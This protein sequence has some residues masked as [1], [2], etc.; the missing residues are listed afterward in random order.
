MRGSLLS[1]PVLPETVESARPEP[2]VG[3]RWPLGLLVIGFPL[4]WLLGLS[5]ILPILLTLPLLR[6]LAKKRSILVPRGF[7]WWLLFLI[8]MTAGVTLLW[9]N[10]PGAVPGGGFSRILVFGYRFLWYASC[11]V[12]LLWIINTKKEELADSWVVRLL[13]W[14]FVVVVA[15]GLL[16]MLAPRFEVTSLV[17]MLLPGSLR[18][19]SFVS[20]IVHPAAANLTMFL[21]RPEYR[22]IAP[23]AFANSWGSNLSMYLPFFLLGWFSAK[24]GWRR[25]AG[26]VILVL[27]AAPVVYS[28]NRGLWASLGLGL[29]ILLGYLVVRGPKRHRFKLVA[30][31]VLAVLVGSVAFSV[32]PL[33]D[34]AIERLDNAHSNDRR[35][36]LLTQTVLSAAEGSPV[37]G[38]GSTRDV[39]G[40][41]ASI[42]GGGT[43]DCPACEVPPLGTQGHIWLV[44]FSQGL[45]GAAFFLLFFLRQAWEFWRIC[46]GLQLVGMTLLCFFALQMF[47]YDT[48]G[49]PLYTIMSGLGLMWRERYADQPSNE[50]PR[51]SSYL[52]WDRRHKLVLVSTVTLMVLIGAFWTSSRPA[53]FSAQTSLLLAPSPMYLS[54]TTGEGSNSI[55][56]DTEAALVLTQS[57]LDKVHEAYPE[58][59]SEQVRSAV[60]ISATPNSRVLH[61][62][63]TGT[64][65]HRTTDI[66]S[67]IANEYLAVRNQFLQ[68]RKEQVLKD[69]QSQLAALSPDATEEAGVDWQLN[70]DGDQARDL[71]LRDSIIDLTVSETSAGEILRATTTSPAK[72]QPEVVV[73]SLA[74][75]G[76][77]PAVV[78]HLQ[79][80][81]KRGRRI[82]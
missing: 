44:I 20:S 72:N 22:P 24:S 66:T 27:A 47:I 25:I 26:P 23:F 32:S 34:T 61:V 7:G 68:Q 40:S 46:T 1:S 6:Q 17:E 58:L 3:A 13:G 18:S 54:G 73:V 56:V 71:E 38:F 77:L 12:V 79:A 14:M 80:Q 16:G 43:P 15:G 51:L 53:Q 39:Q 21:G 10:A 65:R 28:M 59:S 2:K 74:L 81:R 76:M 29:L 52:R 57:T 63:Y 62:S 82:R 78:L 75:L 31:V 70:A 50:A 49:M 69:L 60:S 64:D 42:A 67:M 4:W 48:L 37:A 11:T 45:I 33:A 55:T 30:S 19:N 8:W 41:F 35:S 5:A 9:A 36:Q